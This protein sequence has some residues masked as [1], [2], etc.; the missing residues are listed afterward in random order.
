MKY[1]TSISEH[2]LSACLAQ[3]SH[4]VA[5]Q[6]KKWRLQVIAFFC[7][8]AL[9]GSMVLLQT[10]VFFP[11]VWADHSR[12]VIIAV[13]VAF[14]VIIFTSA[15]VSS[16]LHSASTEIKHE[17]ND[18]HKVNYNIELNNEGMRVNAVS[19]KSQE[20]TQYFW[21]TIK[22]VY[23]FN[24]GIMILGYAKKAK[25]SLLLPFNEANLQS[26]MQ[27]LVD[28]MRQHLP[29]SIFVSGHF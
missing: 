9:L 18:S 4:S 27:H 22:K 21:A 8:I 12:I 29:A 24:N 11:T 28:E 16:H 14:V 13:L 10:G 7:A 26:T 1:L 3:A 17:Q 5:I 23:V 2:E 25:A 20:S 19:E 6:Q 15:F